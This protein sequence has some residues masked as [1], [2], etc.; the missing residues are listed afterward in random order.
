MCAHFILAANPYTL[1]LSSRNTNTKPNW[2]YFHCRL[3]MHQQQICSILGQKNT[4]IYHF[5]LQKY[6]KNTPEKSPMSMPFNQQFKS[7]WG[8]MTGQRESISHSFRT[9]LTVFRPCFLPRVLRT[10]RSIPSMFYCHENAWSF[11][12]L[13]VGC[14]QVL[15]IQCFTEWGLWLQFWCM[16]YLIRWGFSWLSLRFHKIGDY[17]S[18]EPISLNVW[19]ESAEK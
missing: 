2:R 15:W 19:R 3:E 10:Q 1:I 7:S 13:Y 18:N 11:N 4:K 5:L 9:P 6:W 17:I 14:L 8:L 12:S 16:S